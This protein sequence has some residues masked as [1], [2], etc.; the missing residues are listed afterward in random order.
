[1]VPPILFLMKLKNIVFT[2]SLLLNMAL[3]ASICRDIAQKP[4]V[5]QP[6]KS[7]TMSEHFGQLK[8]KPSPMRVASQ[9]AVRSAMSKAIVPVNNDYSPHTL[10]SELPPQIQ[11]PVE[12]RSGEQISD[13]EFSKVSEATRRKLHDALAPIDDELA[14]VRQACSDFATANDFAEIAKLEQRRLAFIRENLTAVEFTKYRLEH[15]TEGQAISKLVAPLTI[16]DADKLAILDESTDDSV[17]DADK[18]ILNIQDR[19]GYDAALACDFRLDSRYDRIEGFARRFQL[20]ESQVPVV[21]TALRMIEFQDR[22]SIQDRN[23][24][25]DQLRSIVP[26]EAWTTF[27]DAFDVSDPVP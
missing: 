8:V 24:A 10:A 6:P 1:M 4:A 5:H 16:S 9:D 25:L 13:E 19:F 27:V 21:L 17:F 23:K 20:D 7:S 14:R 22:F 12:D 3:I 2:G 26:V 11:A 15:T 18:A